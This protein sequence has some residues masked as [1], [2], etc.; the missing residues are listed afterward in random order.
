MARLGGDEFAVF[1]PLLLPLADL[2]KRAKELCVKL[3]IQLDGM[4]ISGTIGIA[5]APLHGSDYQTLYK[6]ADSALLAAKRLGKNQYKIFDTQMEMPSPSLYR[7]MD[8]LLDETSDAIVIC[9]MNSYEILYL[10]NVAAKIAGKDKRLCI[11]QK[12]YETLWGRNQPCQHCIACSKLTP[13]YIEQEVDDEINHR[14]YII[15]D[16][17]M[18]WGGNYARIQYIQDG[19]A[20]NKIKNELVQ[21][22]ERFSGM[23]S[24]LQAGLVKC[25]LNEEWTVLEANEQFYEIIGY[26]KEEFEARFDNSLTAVMEPRYLEENRDQLKQQLK[27]DEKVVMDSCFIN[28]QGNPVFVTDQTVVVTE[29]DGKSYFYCTYIRKADIQI[30]QKGGAAI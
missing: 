16:K 10:N 19:T 12:C 28:R 5:N 6:N 3:Q 29:S 24:S 4:R 20:R 25:L 1:V 15:R 27:I 21:A 9:D 26:S 13:D 7:N 18:D 8:W 22:N 11:G 23:L 14:H 30:P 2:Q 17:L